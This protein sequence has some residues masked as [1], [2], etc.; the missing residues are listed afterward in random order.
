MSTQGDTSLCVEPGGID[1]VLVIEPVVHR[2]DRGSFREVFKLGDF[3]AATGVLRQWPQDNHSF[4]RAGVLRGIHYQ[5]DPPQGKLVTCPV[6]EIFDVAVDLRRSSPTFGSWVGHILSEENGR[7]LWVPEGFGHGFLV[8]SE[9]ADVLYKVTAEHNPKGYFSVAWD[10]PVLGIDWPLRSPP[11]MSE[12]DRNADSVAAA[13]L[14][15]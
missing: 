3:E 7:Q 11:V 12:R 15:P 5:L 9:V 10:D 13:T 6:G 4:S 8:L 14:F 2:D 1:G